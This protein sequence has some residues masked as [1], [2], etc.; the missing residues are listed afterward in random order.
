MQNKEYKIR[1]EV[2]P[3]DIKAVEEI[4][5]STGFFRNDEVDVAVELVQ[6]RLDKG[7]E[8]GYDFVFIDI[9]NKTVAYSCYGLIPCSLISYD[10]YWIATH[11]DYRNKGLGKIVLTE[12]EN[13]IRKSGGKA[14]YIETSSKEKYI[15]TQKFYENNNCELKISFEDFYD[16]G[17]SKFVYVKKL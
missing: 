7:V 4:I 3:S 6:E 5:K 1:C 11:Q 9:D 16:I 17:D 14:M 12:T 2:K 15:P 13:Q 10:L 8:S